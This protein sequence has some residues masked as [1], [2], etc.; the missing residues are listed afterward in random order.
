M[1]RSARRRSKAQK[2]GSSSDLSK[3]DSQL[4]HA[5]RGKHVSTSC[6]SCDSASFHLQF[7]PFQDAEAELSK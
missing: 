4:F 5:F 7:T 3:S 6:L 2:P 1:P